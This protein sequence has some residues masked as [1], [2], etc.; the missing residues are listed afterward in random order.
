MSSEEDIK[1]AIAQLQRLQIH[2]SE[3][4]QHLGQLRKRGENTA[5]RQPDT[6]RGFAIEDFA[7]GN[8]V[9]IK[10]P[11]LFQSTRG[12]I[13]KIGIICITVQAQN[14]TKIV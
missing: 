2:Q 13:I 12:T 14:G 5:A 9:R 11:G 10:N 6:T 1:E 8:K 3:L 7:M 4:L